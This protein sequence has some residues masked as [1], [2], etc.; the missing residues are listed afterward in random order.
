MKK[1]IFLSVVLLGAI[2]LL[3][4]VRMGNKDRNKRSS[5]HPALP[6]GPQKNEDW[7]R[8]RAFEETDFP[9]PPSEFES[10]RQETENLRQP[11]FSCQEE[12]LLTL[13]K[14]NYENL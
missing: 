8:S 12:L 10:L 11:V 6:Y 1:I 5:A 13:S 14:D 4:Q 9:A 3:G 7:Y 2:S